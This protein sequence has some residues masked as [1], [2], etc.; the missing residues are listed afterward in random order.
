MRYTIA[1]LAFLALVTEL[2]AQGQQPSNRI[3]RVVVAIAATN[4]E[5]TTT[6]LT[7]NKDDLLIVSAEKLGMFCKTIS[8]SI[9]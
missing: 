6:G 8:D 9:D 5:W 3:R 1:T 7:V 4:D 2:N